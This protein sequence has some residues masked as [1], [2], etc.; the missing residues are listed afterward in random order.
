MRSADGVAA[1]V[2]VVGSFNQ[3]HVW[4]SAQFPAPGV[5]RIGQFSTGPGGKGF[6]QAVA[7]VR[8]GV[9][10]AFIAAIGC[11]PLGDTAA[12]LAQTE[13]LRAR[14]QRLNGVA[15]GSAAILLDAGGQNMIVVG[16]GANAALTAG[17]VAQQAPLIRAARVLLT[18]QE[19]TVDACVEAMTIARQHNVLTVHNP[20]PEGGGDDY[21][22]VLALT[23]VLTPNESEFEALLASHGVVPEPGWAQRG[24][25]ATLHGLCARLGVPTIVIT[26]GAAGAFVSHHGDQRRGDAEPCYRVPAEAVAV[27]D[28][29]GAGDAFNG[30]LAAALATAPAQP[31]AAAIR[32][33]TRTAALAV[34][35]AGAALAMPRADELRARFSE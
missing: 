13:G 33:A 23:D 9:H 5:T 14:W 35:R 19:T 8:Q 21:R 15:T 11:D 10:T 34:E 18:Q 25:D 3:D 12:A 26:L 7:C 4:R 31:F 1:Q 2:V 29:T 6:N 24:D 28:S 17:H 32:Q 30:G 20:A 16:P 22:A 27:V